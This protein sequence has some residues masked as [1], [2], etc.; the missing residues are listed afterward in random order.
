[1]NSIDL[2]IRSSFENDSRARQRQVPR[3]QPCPPWWV[4][5]TLLLVAIPAMAAEQL[6]LR[7]DPFRGRNLLETTRT[8][9]YIFICVNSFSYSFQNF[10]L[11][12]LFT[13]SKPKR[14]PP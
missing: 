4:G 12:S 3:Q 1:M 2:G 7:G 10:K 5:L 9:L 8:F 14:I 11:L 6:T 13:I